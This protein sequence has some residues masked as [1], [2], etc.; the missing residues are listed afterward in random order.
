MKLKKALSILL[1]LTM[2]AGIFPCGTLAADTETRI[3]YFNDFDEEITSNANVAP[4][5]NKID[6][7]TEDD[8][9]GAVM[10]STDGRST[11]DAFFQATTKGTDYDNVVVEIS[12][13]CVEGGLATNMQFKDD[14][15][16][17]SLLFATDKN[18]NITSSGS[19]KNLGT[20]QSGKWIELAFAIDF[21]DR[22]YSTYVDGKGVE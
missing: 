20:I 21:T 3:V 9:N 4:K 16:K 22:A 6:A 19:G 18:G 13:S 8:G 15:P 10:I 12:L 17:Q 7:Y 1:V 2:A 14:V 5:S 11:E